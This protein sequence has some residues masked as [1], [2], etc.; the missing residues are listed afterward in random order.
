M[1]FCPTC[2]APVQGRF[3]AK[4]GASVDAGASAPPPP[5][6]SQFGGT[7]FGGAEFGRGASAPPPPPQQGGLQENM[8]NALCY[9][10]GLIT[11]ILFLVLEPHSKNRNTRFHAF[12]SIFFSIALFAVQ[13]ALAIVSGI[14]VTVSP[15]LMGGLFSLIW[16]AFGLGVLALWIYLMYKAYNNQRVVLPII[17]P[18]AEKQA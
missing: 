6:P 16:L 5:P 17:G 7:Q 1:A 14:L 2:G 10:L 3:C 15:L 13:I 4:C 11:G 12:Q 18:L 8:A 9:L